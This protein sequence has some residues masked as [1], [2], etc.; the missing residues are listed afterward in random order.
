MFWCFYKYLSPT[1]NENVL[2][3]DGGNKP[4]CRTG[5]NLSPTENER[6]LI[7][8]GGNKPACWTGANFI[9]YGE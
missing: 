9:F 1:E 5:A 2:L 6:V 8:D 7:N 4:A 3:N